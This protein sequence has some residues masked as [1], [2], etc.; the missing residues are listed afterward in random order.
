MGGSAII[1]SEAAPVALIGLAALWLVAGAFLAVRGLRDR[2]RAHLL[3]GHA[4]AIGALLAAAPVR[5][6]LVIKDGSI[7][8]DE[9][10][11]RELGVAGAR[12]FD[13]LAGQG[14]MLAA[15]HRALSDQLGE[16]A[17]GITPIERAVTIE[18]SGRRFDVRGGAAPPPSPP[19]SVLLWI[20][21][22]SSA[23]RD[24]ATMAEQLGATERAMSALTQ[25]IEA[26]PFPM[27]VRDGSLRLALV[28]RAFVSAVEAPDVG[29]VVERG[30]ELI[31]GGGE[32]SA[33]AGARTGAQGWPP[34]RAGPPGH[35]RRRAADAATG[36]R[37]TAGWN[38]CGLCRRY[39]GTGG[40]PLRA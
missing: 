4:R 5:P 21:E 13:D 11:L 23:E 12:T 2:R 33:R 8:A 20:G 25:L 7:E 28:N 39:P 3:T 27:W 19:G 1:A 34:D 18:A 15:D 40:C 16:A 14:G 9:A 31:E 22:S 38:R 26:A 37:P 32:G 35:H 10:L 24:R 17:M 6:L 30:I 29:A 36:R